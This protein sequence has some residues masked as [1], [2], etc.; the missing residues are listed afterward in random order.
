MAG[1]HPALAKQY[2]Q[3]H[4][5]NKSKTSAGVSQTSLNGSRDQVSIM[6]LNSF[7][8]S[9]PKFTQVMSLPQSVMNYQAN[10][11]RVGNLPAKMLSP[12]SQT[13]VKTSMNS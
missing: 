9:T 10:M 2:K 11:S 13:Q 8:R 6:S 12:Q 7:S 3:E 1:Y 4:N 5:L